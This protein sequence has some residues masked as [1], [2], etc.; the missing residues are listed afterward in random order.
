MLGALVLI[1]TLSSFS[2]SRTRPFSALDDAQ[3][4]ATRIPVDDRLEQFA[5]SARRFCKQYLEPNQMKF[6]AQDHVERE[7]WLKAGE[8]GLILP[9]V[10]AE[11]G[12]S[13]STRGIPRVRAEGDAQ[14]DF[15][16]T[17]HGHAAAAGPDPEVVGLAGEEPRV[18]ERA[19]PLVAGQPRL[20]RVVD[21]ASAAA[22]RTAA[23]KHTRIGHLIAATSRWHWGESERAF[24]VLAEPDRLGHQDN[25]P[26]LTVCAGLER[27]R[28]A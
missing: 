6:R 19:G 14:Y 7:V 27:S 3:H 25:S 20:R 22:A 15:A 16:R 23:L 5:A 9:D 12:G 1:P 24:A 18:R 2:S 10:H 4:R 11:Y 17:R 8:L 21:A 26:R 13:G 28:L